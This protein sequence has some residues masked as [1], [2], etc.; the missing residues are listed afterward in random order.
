MKE[1]ISPDG[2]SPI[3]LAKRLMHFKG[4]TGS[5]VDFETIKKQ[6]VPSESLER[7]N[8]IVRGLEQEDE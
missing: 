7:V 3:E 4:M 1:F 8:Q 2:I 6:L 5:K